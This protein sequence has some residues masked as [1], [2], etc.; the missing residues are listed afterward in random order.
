MVPAVW[1]HLLNAVCTFPNCAVNKQIT[2]T[3]LFY[4]WNRSQLCY[5]LFL[6]A[7][8]QR[9]EGIW[10]VT[11]PWSLF[12]TG[13]MLAQQIKPLKLAQ[14]GHSDIDY[15]YH[16]DD[17]KLGLFLKRHGFRWPLKCI[18]DEVTKVKVAH[19]GIEALETKQ[20]ASCMLT[21]IDC[22]G[23]SGLL[24]QQ[25]WVN[26]SS[27]I[28]A[29]CPNARWQSVRKRC[30]KTRYSSLILYQKAFNI[31]LA[32]SIPLQSRTGKRLMYICSLTL[33]VNKP[34]NRSDGRKLMTLEVRLCICVGPPGRKPTLEG[35][36]SSRGFITRFSSKHWAPHANIAQQTCEA[37]IEFFEN[38]HKRRAK[39]SAV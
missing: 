8:N 12:V 9:R 39:P 20:N 26:S 13:P 6:S 33:S 23:F 35:K 22:S 21:F 37:F 38:A 27:I 4:S 34:L 1:C 10:T 31:G 14:Y 3:S 28:R 5:R 29:I 16:F 15:A 25:L 36:M 2:A 7:C 11:V 18:D 19:L 17:T 24:I 32:M 30:R